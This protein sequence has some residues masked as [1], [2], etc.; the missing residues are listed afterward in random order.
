ML[1]FGVGMRKLTFIAMV[2][3]ALSIVT[4]A[5]AADFVEPTYDWNGVYAGVFAGVGHTSSDW[6][7]TDSDDNDG[8]DAVDIDETLSE[9]TVLLGGLVGVNFQKD[10]LVF[11]AEADLAWFDSREDESLDGA[12]GLDITSDID[13]LG[14]L[15]ARLGYAEDRTLFYV[16]GGL[17]FANA[18]HTWNDH[19][20]EDFNLPSKSVDLDFG[21]VVGAGIEHAWTDNWLIRLEGFYYDL[22]SE[23]ATVSNENETD[24]FE[25]KQDIWVGRIGFSYKLN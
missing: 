3:T 25:V 8:S 21:W 22:G 10:K 7:G 14:S 12:E 19:G 13:L 20:S 15:R 5:S 18:K 17:A 23:D 9:T 4:P 6:D 1:L 16:T 24:E 2:G 11:G